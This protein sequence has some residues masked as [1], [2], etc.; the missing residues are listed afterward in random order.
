V[1][2]NLTEENGSGWLYGTSLPGQMVAYGPS[3]VVHARTGERCA[4]GREVGKVGG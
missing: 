1:G 2:A 3:D 4:C